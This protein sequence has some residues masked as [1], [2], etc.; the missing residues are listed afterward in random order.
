[1]FP[2][3]LYGE[4]KSRRHQRNLKMNLKPLEPMSNLRFQYPIQFDMDTDDIVEGGLKPSKI[5]NKNVRG[6][7]KLA[8]KVSSFSH[9][10][11]RVT[12]S[13]FQKPESTA[14]NFTDHSF[15]HRD[16]L[17]EHDTNKSYD[18][19]EDEGEVEYSLAPEEEC[20]SYEIKKEMEMMVLLGEVFERVMY[21]KNAYVSLQDAHCPWNPDKIRL[22]DVAVVTELTKLGLLR[23]RFHRSIRRN[24]TTTDLML[25]EMLAPYEVALEKLTADVK[26]KADLIDNLRDKLKSAIKGSRKKSRSSKVNCSSRF[27][28]PSPSPTS[29]TIS[30]AKM[31]VSDQ[32]ESCMSSVKEASKTFAKL[33]LSLMKSAH[34][35]ITATVK[36]I[37]GITTTTTTAV[38]TSSLESYINY[39]IF[40]GFNHESFNMDD[41][42]KSSHM[43]PNQYR[44]EC[45]TQYTYMK[46]VD[47][48]ELLRIIPTCLFGK[49]CLNKYLSLMHPK[50]E[51]SLLGDLEQRQQVLA[52]NHPRSRFYNEFLGVV[53]AVWLLHLFAFSLDPL[54]SHFEGDQGAEFHPQYMESVVP[55][56]VVGG[57]DV[58][59]FPVSPGFK[60]G[61]GYVVK[62]RVY[63]V[64]KG[65]L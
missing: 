25:R 21:M 32:F 28:A 4:G 9:L 59:G 47:P 58:V 56:R 54:P 52:E 34:W 29:S 6:I 35:D 40:Q 55:R 24:T 41:G 26:N 49:F 22:S 31:E 10:I 33:L 48:M 43:N 3:M 8:N 13:C 65:E 57:E 5:S 51:I 11:H 7:T 53:K 38:V 45:F 50:M 2:S 12:N 60:L 61:N 46:S 36:S 44:T 63:L 30:A 18:Y 19:F 16:E 23:D 1:M 62:A 20:V 37:T 42:N 15:G 17:E 39:K 14:S 27:E 64:P